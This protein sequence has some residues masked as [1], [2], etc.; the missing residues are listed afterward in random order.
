MW[1][2]EN[3]TFGLFRT[4]HMLGGRWLVLAQVVAPAREGNAHK[5]KFRS[6]LADAAENSCSASTGLFPELRIWEAQL[7]S[8][9]DMLKDVVRC[10]VSL[11]L[12]GADWLTS[13]NRQRRE[14]MI[15]R[16]WYDQTFFAGDAGGLLLQ[17]STEPTGDV[18]ID[19]W[20]MWTFPR[21]GV[22]F[23]RW[24]VSSSLAV[25]VSASSNARHLTAWE[26]SC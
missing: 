23:R 19:W 1:F 5:R 12:S 6:Q 8:R 7:A 18:A 22:G 11:V 26:P 25:L 2:T 3:E 21:K 10:V 14:Y 4:G 9:D 15:V 17:K 24:R 16:E 13:G 20:T